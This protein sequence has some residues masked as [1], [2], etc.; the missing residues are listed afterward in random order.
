V[1]E[2]ALVTAISFQLS[3]FQRRASV[4]KNIVFAIFAF[5]IGLS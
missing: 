4:A 5:L 2:L 1:L 3:G